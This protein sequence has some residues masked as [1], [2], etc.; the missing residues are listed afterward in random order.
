VLRDHKIEQLEKILTKAVDFK[1]KVSLAKGMRIYLESLILLALMCSLVIK[2]NVFSIV[3]LVFV[4]RYMIAGKQD[5]MAIFI[6]INWWLCL[7]I[8]IQYALVLLNLTVI[9]SP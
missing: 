3:Y 2:S 5:K 8:M 7:C 6:K 9:T 4:L 1:Y